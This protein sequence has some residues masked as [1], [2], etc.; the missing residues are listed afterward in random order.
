MGEDSVTFLN[1]SLEDREPKPLTI[2]Y[3]VRDVSLSCSYRHLHH[4]LNVT[5]H[6]QMSD[7]INTSQVSVC[8]QVENLGVKGLPVSV[9]LEMT[10]ETTHV[11]LTPQSFS[12]MEVFN[13]S[14]HE[15]SLFDC[16]TVMFC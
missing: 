15:F 1:F 12:M 16:V 5:H 11:K 4:S 8:V 14:L 3:K 7:A 6:V 13:L 10:C 9:T 2:I